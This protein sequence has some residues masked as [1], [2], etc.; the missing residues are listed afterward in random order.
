MLFAA[1]EQEVFTVT[2]HLSLVAM[3]VCLTPSL[4]S[5]Q[6]TEFTVKVQTAAVRQ[7]RAL[8]VQSSGKRREAR[9]SKSHATSARGSRSRG[10][11]PPTAW[12]T[13]TRPW[14]RSRNAP[15]RRAADDHV[16]EPAAARTGGGPGAGGRAVRAINRCV[17]STRT[18]YVPP[19]THFVGLGGQMRGSTPGFGFTSRLWSRRRLGVQLDC[20][21]RD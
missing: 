12:A 7:P 10:R 20:R 15:P 4:A 2:R 16:R 9:R 21:S 6:G 3:V 17:A 14:E 18:I 5:A 1:W 13:S 8:G 11:R 19:P